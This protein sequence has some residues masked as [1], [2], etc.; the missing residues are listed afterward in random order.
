MMFKKRHYPLKKLLLRIDALVSLPCLRVFEAN[1][2]T[3]NEDWSRSWGSDHDISDYRE[4]S[5]EVVSPMNILSIVLNRLGES[6]EP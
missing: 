5:G 3:Q 1:S 2:G 4:S 6:R